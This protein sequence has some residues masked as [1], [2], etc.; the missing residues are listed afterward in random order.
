MN[1]LPINIYQ[2]NWEL[3]SSKEFKC[4]NKTMAQKE[5]RHW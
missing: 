2:Q 3:G 5:K 4:K 1:R